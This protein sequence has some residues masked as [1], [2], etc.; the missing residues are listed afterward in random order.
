MLR[1]VHTSGAD[2]EMMHDT[3]IDLPAANAPT[4]AVELTADPMAGHN[5]HIITS[6]F[7]YAPQQASLAHTPGEGHAHVYINGEKLGPRLWALAAHRQ[8][9]Q[10]RG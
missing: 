8:P 7:A 2:H 9:A 4:V 5:L 3:P 6:N 10:G 1:W